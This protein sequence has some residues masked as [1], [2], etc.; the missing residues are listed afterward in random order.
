[1]F[2]LRISLGS[3]FQKTH[4]TLLKYLTYITQQHHTSIDSNWLILVGLWSD[5]NSMSHPGTAFHFVFLVWKFLLPNIKCLSLSLSLCMKLSI[6]RAEIFPPDASVRRL[7]LFETFL[8]SIVYTISSAPKAFAS[9]S[10][11]SA[12][13]LHPHKEC[14][15]QSKAAVQR[16]RLLGPLRTS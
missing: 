1:M 9:S 14:S 4:L 16:G 13:A 12:H 7:H 3:E 8:Y 6:T 15:A 5:E 2:M 11:P 10:L